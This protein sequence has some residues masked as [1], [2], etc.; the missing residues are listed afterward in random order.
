M[1]NPKFTTDNLSTIGGIVDRTVCMIGSIVCL[2]VTAIQ[3]IVSL[4]VKCSID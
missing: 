2:T 3:D 4:M 1:A